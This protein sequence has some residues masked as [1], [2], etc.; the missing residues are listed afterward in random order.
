MPR[1]KTQATSTVAAVAIAG[2]LIAGV[3]P[4]PLLHADPALPI[5]QLAGRWVGEG[6]LGF[7]DGK[8]ENVKCRV[9]YF[10]SADE[11]QIKQNIRCA[12]P[13]GSIDVQSIMTNKADRLLGTW[14]ETV[15]N[16]HG[17]VKGQATKNG[18]R[19]VVKGDGLNANM[20]LILRG[21]S[22][23]VEIQF[24]DSTLIGL[25]LVLARG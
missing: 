23:V 19:V 25:S 2:S 17:D 7:R 1:P 13:S 21:G 8:I 20:D 3:L 12:S 16:M 15:Y 14:T 6:R 18:F 10:V 4:A 11:E 5:G 24:H 22:Q 9:T